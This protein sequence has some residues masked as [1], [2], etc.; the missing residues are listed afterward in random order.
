MLYEE[1]R[2]LIEDGDLIAVHEKKGILAALTRFFTRSPVTHTGTAFW[3]DDVLWM[4]ELNGG[5]NHAIPL[6]QLSNTAFD[7]H[8]PPVPDRAA[9]REAIFKNLR[10][11]IPYG[12]IALLL[13]GFLSFFKINIFVH[14]RS[15]I[16]C[17][18][19]SVKIYEDAG[20]NEQS[21][22]IS[23]GNLA[24]KLYKKFSVCPYNL[25]K[26]K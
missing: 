9:I 22:Q 15:V 12:F 2:H 21:R 18:G 8:Y 4:A 6:S 17:S 11:K 1:V 7:V 10:M 19:F 23:P 14:W 26:S 24:A 25:S 20:L 3:M 16:V 13:I 5:R